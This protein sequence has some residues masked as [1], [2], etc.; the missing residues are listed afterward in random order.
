MEI[1]P[2]W[3]MAA[4][5]VDEEHVENRTFQEGYDLFQREYQ[6]KPIPLLIKELQMICDIQQSR[7]YTGETLMTH[8]LD[9]IHDNNVE[10]YLEFLDDT[11]LSFEKNMKKYRDQVMTDPIIDPNEI[12]KIHRTSQQILKLYKSGSILKRQRKRQRPIPF[13]KNEK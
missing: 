9:S 10:G 13:H 1:L 3:K 5:K 12:I 8:F 7:R 6:K 11:I 4:Q 2:R